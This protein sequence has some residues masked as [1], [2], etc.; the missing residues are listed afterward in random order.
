MNY[1]KE[2]KKNNNSFTVASEKY[3]RMNLTKEAKDL[4]TEN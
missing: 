1:G 2:I 4:N 3:L